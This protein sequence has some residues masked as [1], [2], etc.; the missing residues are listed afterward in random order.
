[1]IEIEAEL[2]KVISRRF[3]SDSDLEKLRI[4]LIMTSL[5]HGIPIDA[6]VRAAMGCRD[7]LRDHPEVDRRAFAAKWVAEVQR[8]RRRNMPDMSDQGRAQ[9][10]ALDRLIARMIRIKNPALDHVLA[11]LA[12][13]TRRRKRSAP[14]PSR[15]A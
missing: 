9:R 12:R 3:P 2:A 8:V 7:W 6:H 13:P 1:L 15:R 10:A 4:K 11:S 5:A 14:G